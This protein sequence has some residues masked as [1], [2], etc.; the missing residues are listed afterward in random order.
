MSPR[1]L[2]SLSVPALII[3]FATAVSAQAP[4]AIT[5]DNASDPNVLII[6][7]IIEMVAA[8]LPEE[9][10]ITKIQTSKTKFGLPTPVVVELYNSGVSA[11]VVKAMMT[12]Q[13]APP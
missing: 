4:P 5:S 10:I 13:N 3:T 2:L 9:V 6:Q 8:K 11:N 12:P 7:S 1:W